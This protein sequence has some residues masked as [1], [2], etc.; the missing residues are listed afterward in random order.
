M[1][2][3]RY[4]EPRGWAVIDNPETELA[5]ML[6][7]EYLRSKGHTVKS[8]CNLPEEQARQLWI[9]ASLYVSGKLAEIS[10]RSHLMHN[11]AGTAPPM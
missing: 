7:E 4:H 10:A 3:G 8:V 2:R 6:I 9:E 11:I 1:T 5:R